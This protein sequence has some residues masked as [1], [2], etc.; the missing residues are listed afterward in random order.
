MN[1]KLNNISLNVTYFM[2]NIFFF[3]LFFSFFFPLL[4]LH[5]LEPSP[6]LSSKC[7][8]F[9]YISAW[10]EWS[11]LVDEVYGLSFALKS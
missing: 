3:F 9:V 10:A 5:L 7:L 4:L 2:V 1:N 6:D 8:L 11:N